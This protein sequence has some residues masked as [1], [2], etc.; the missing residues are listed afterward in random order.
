ME[1]ESE[2]KILTTVGLFTYVSLSYC[3]HIAAKVPK[4][5]P[6]LLALL[7]VMILLLI[8]PFNLHSI[9]LG[10]PLVLC[11][12]CHTNFNLFALAFNQG[13]L[14]L[15]KAA[16]LD[17][18]ILSACSPFKIKQ[19][20]HSKV[21]LDLILEAASKGSLWIVLTLVSYSYKECF[22][23]LVWSLLFGFLVWLAVVVL[24]TTVVIPAQGIGNAPSR[25]L[26]PDT[27]R[28]DTHNRSP[29]EFLAARFRNVRRLRSDTRA[30][31]L[32][33]IT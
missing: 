1:V 23:K 10:Y 11:L 20:H 9:Y 17:V 22:H 3:Y 29:M 25:R 26:R 7:P 33:H 19:P 28:F 18:F 32:Q 2:L 4:G 15:P 8:I 6:R 21:P 5:L 24:L 12:S 14:S 16:A 30:A 13:P 31:L 27:K